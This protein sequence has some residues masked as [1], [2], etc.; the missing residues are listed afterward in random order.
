L[1]ADGSGFSR[2]VVR[3]GLE[4]AGYL[5][6]E[7]EDLDGVIGCLEQQPV[8]IILA[9]LDLPPGGVAALPAVLR[10]RPEWETIPI[11][12]LADSA[13]EAQ[14]AAAWTT[15]FQ[16]CQVKLDRSHVLESVARLVASRPPAVQ[17]A[18]AQR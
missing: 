15:G 1:V 13:A 10:R 5:V 3:A 6:V 9:A 11:L 7:A 4:M 14:S 18:G 12:A 8:E 16:D 2:A 17:Y